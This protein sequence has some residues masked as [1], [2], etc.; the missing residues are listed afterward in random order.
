ESHGL[1]VARQSQ[2]AYAAAFIEGFVASHDLVGAVVGAVRGDDDFQTIL[3]II[4]AEQVVYLLL[5]DVNLIVGR[6]DQADRWCD[7]LLPPRARAHGATQRNEQRE[8]QVGVDD[9]RGGAPE[10]KHGHASASRIW[11]A[12]CRAF[13]LRLNSASTFWR[14]AWPRRRRRGAERC[15]RA[16]AVARP[17]T[18]RGSARRPVC[19]S[20]TSSGMPERRLATTGRP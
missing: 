8:E 14:P 13:S 4:Q 17:S 15:R 1:A 18:S 9:E 2:Q 16:S 12:N 10:E 5:D 3:G 11:S 19:P 7:L 20:S 6:D